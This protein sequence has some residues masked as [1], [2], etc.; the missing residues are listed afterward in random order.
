MIGCQSN[1]QTKPKR[2][3]TITYNIPLGPMWHSAIHPSWGGEP[4]RE[5]CTYPPYSCHRIRSPMLETSLNPFQQSTIVRVGGET[6]I[7]CVEYPSYL[8]PR[9]RYLVPIGLMWQAA[10]HA[11]SGGVLRRGSHIS[12]SLLVFPQ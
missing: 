2:G 1:P 3:Y 6:K 7:G 11:P 12:F 8:S 10:N 5:A 9:A 4:S